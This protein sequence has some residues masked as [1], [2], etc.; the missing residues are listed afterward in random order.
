MT[1]TRLVIGMNLGYGLL[2]GEEGERRGGGS[3]WQRKGLVVNKGVFEFLD[4]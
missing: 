2:R 1:R 4:V 3:G